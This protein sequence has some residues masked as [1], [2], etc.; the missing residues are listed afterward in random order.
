MR[1]IA[2]VSIVL[3]LIGTLSI[4]ITMCQF[5]SLNSALELGIAS[6]TVALVTVCFISI[7][8]ILYNGADKTNNTWCIVLWQRAN[9]FKIILIFIGVVILIV[10]SMCRMEGSVSFAVSA[11]GV[12]VLS[13]TGL[14][15]LILYSNL[16]TVHNDCIMKCIL[17]FNLA[18]SPNRSSIPNTIISAAYLEL[19]L[20]LHLV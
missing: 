8:V 7:D 6:F 12:I 1:L 3:F 15:Q 17:G 14:V 4:N 13:T 19:N 10:L 9:K 20:S 18:A 16:K 2:T 11:T 5:Y